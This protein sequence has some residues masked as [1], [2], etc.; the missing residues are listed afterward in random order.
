MLQI[1]KILTNFDNDRAH[2]PSWL[3]S[4]CSA[5]GAKGARFVFSAGLG[6]IEASEVRL[7]KALL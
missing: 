7:F 6:L 2:V 1:W 4:L 3:S 5:S